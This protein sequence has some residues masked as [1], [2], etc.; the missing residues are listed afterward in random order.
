MI[1]RNQ[2]EKM[3]RRGRYHLENGWPMMGTL[4]LLRIGAEQAVA[5]VT[6]HQLLE[7]VLTSD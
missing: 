2:V 3:Y 1:G 7:E 4:K 5:S 6:V